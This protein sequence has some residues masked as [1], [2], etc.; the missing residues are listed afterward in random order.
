MDWQNENK[1]A[2]A[3][4]GAQLRADIPQMQQAKGQTQLASA[5]ERHQK[6]LSLIHERV[7]ALERRLGPVLRPSGPTEAVGKLN[8]TS[9]PMAPLAGALHQISDELQ[10]V[11]Y[12]LADVLE[13]LEL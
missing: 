7:V 4:Y 8:G 13:R 1:A 12:I 9:G 3:G 10:Q 11:D 2:T 5:A 6:L